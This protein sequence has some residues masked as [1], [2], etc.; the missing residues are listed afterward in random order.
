MCGIAGIYNKDGINPDRVIIEKMSRSIAHRGPD[1]EGYHLDDTVQLA[2][3]RL[4]IIDLQTGS[5]PIYSED[6]T[7]CIIFNGE[8]YNYQ[9]LRQ[10]LI[11]R[12]FTFR[13]RSD[14]EVILQAYAAWGEE[15][16]TRLSGMFALCIWD[17]RRRELFLA[18]D[19]F[20]IKPL[21]ITQLPEGTVLFASE[22]K[23]LL[24]HPTVKK[25]LYPNAIDNLLTYGF[26]LAPHTFFEGIQQVLPGH[27]IKINEQGFSTGQYWDIDMDSPLL[28]A[29]GS[30]LARLFRERFQQ[31]VKE[32][33]VA[34]VPV[35]AYLSGGID[36]S[37]VAGV[38]S[39]LAEEKVSTIT[40]TF[41]SAE[42]DESAYSKKVSSFFGTK[43]IEFKCA[44]GPEEIH[45]LIYYLENPLVSLLN[46]PLFLLSK[47]TREL[48]I[49][50]VL[51][52]DGADEVL[53]GYDY[54]KLVK[55]MPFIE[56]TGSHF[57]KNILRR[58]YPHLASADKAE[59]QYISLYNAAA[60]FPLAHPAMPYRFQ[61]FQQKEELYSAD[62]ANLLNNTPLDNPFFFNPEAIAHRPL[63]DQALY[64]EA[65]MRLL[66]LTLPLSD[67][68]SMANSVEVR[69]LFLDHEL[70]DFTFR[71]PHH[72]KL[73]GMSEKYILKK[74]M[75][76]LLP[77]EICKRKKQPLTPPGRWFVAAAGDMLRELLSPEK[78]KAAGYFNPAF[79]ASL[80]A[81]YRNN[82][83]KDVSGV[84]VVLFF[85]QLW[86]EI[87]L[88]EG[89]RQ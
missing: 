25:R 78:I 65:K 44:I 15:C 28:D 54:F 73:Q 3:R 7:R 40:I 85:I 30:E 46:L 21:Y 37:A 36:S 9:A 13:T 47:K 79:V 63:I 69:P 52:G 45:S 56:Q 76:G 82:P 35:A 4:S 86:H 41:D 58:I 31:S 67:K 24:Q 51:S 53:G 5:Q 19:R 43:N 1:E 14:T 27:W 61:E 8:I 75:Q 23:A 18:R 29:S 16:L 10:Q 57:R 83:L 11:A 32:S 2:S 50:V 89:V 26:N 74:S 12:G 34:D 62:F 60:R 39:R 42:Y 33:L 71:I 87:F 55:A 59:L 20:G 84:L 48:G 49:K 6:K 80:L 77:P 88:E 64:M 22:I 72:Y 68:M 38:Y 17:S 81:D 70:V 66:N